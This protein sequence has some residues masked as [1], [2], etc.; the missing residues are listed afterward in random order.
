MDMSLL[1]NHSKL[2]PI[3]EPQRLSQPAGLERRC[4]LFHTCGDQD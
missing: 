2:R 1:R 3:A 4:W